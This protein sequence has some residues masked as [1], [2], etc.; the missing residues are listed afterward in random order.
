MYPPATRLLLLC[1]GLSSCGGA[2]ASPC[3]QAGADCR[4]GRDDGKQ[5]TIE[6][7]AMMMMLLLLYSVY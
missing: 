1:A 2:A 4:P 7:L 6:K 5:Q 3:A